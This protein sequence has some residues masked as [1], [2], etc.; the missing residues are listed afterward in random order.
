VRIPLGGGVLAASEEQPHKPVVLSASD[1]STGSASTGW[2]DT[3][4]D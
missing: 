1:T 4:A 2:T 3:T